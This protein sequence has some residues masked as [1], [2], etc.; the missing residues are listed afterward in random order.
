MSLVT[1]VIQ[2]QEDGSVQTK[3]FV[4]PP[5]NLED[6]TPLEPAQR[7]GLIALE[8]LR[9]FVAQATGEDAEVEVG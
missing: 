5:L 9:D 3:V 6:D 7:L 4:D 1:I 2:D 8:G